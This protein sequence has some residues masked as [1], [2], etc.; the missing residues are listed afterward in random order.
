MLIDLQKRIDA[1]NIQTLQPMQPK[2]NDEFSSG[3]ATVI[4]DAMRKGKIR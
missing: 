4:L 1:Q 2:L 3:I